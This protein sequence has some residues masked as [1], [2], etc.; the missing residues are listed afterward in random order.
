[1]LTVRQLTSAVLTIQL[2]IMLSL[3]KKT[4]IMV[5]TLMEDTTTTSNL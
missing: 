5:L 4:T 3:T 1:M 2:L